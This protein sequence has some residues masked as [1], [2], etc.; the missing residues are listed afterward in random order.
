MMILSLSICRSLTQPRSYCIRQPGG[1]FFSGSVSSI[2]HLQPD[3]PNLRPASVRSVSAWSFTSY[4]FT[5]HAVTAFKAPVTAHA[6]SIRIHISTHIRFISFSVSAFSFLCTCVL[7][8]LHVSTHARVAAGAMW[9]GIKSEPRLQDV[10]AAGQ[11]PFLSFSTAYTSTQPCQTHYSYPSQGKAA[12]FL[13]PSLTHSC[14]PS[15]IPTYAKLLTLS[16]VRTRDVSMPC[17]KYRTV[18]ASTLTYKVYTQCSLLPSCKYLCVHAAHGTL[19]SALTDTALAL[20]TLSIQDAFY[21]MCKM[22]HQ[23][24][25]IVGRC[26]GSSS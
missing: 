15:A 17:G 1:V 23:V 5:T 7:F 6:A 8:L 20:Q 26:C 12:P 14:P 21:K 10:S 2:Q 16:S 13:P 24:P 9:P 18:L 22:F 19:H 4:H 3:G 11:T 25:R